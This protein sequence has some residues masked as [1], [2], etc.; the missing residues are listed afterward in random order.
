MEI[1][2]ATIGH[3][4]AVYRLMCELECRD[5][6]KYAFLRIYQ[7]NIADANVCYML[8]VDK[9]N[10]VGFASLHMQKLLHYCAKTGEIQEIIISEK[11][12][13]LGAE[14]ALFRQMVKTAAANGC[15]YLEVCARKVRDET[16]QF[17]ISQ[18][19][20][21]SHFKFMLDLAPAARG[22]KGLGL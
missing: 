10:I 6:D 4:D 9:N 7:E 8:A 14:A 18:G 11:Y 12:Q 17:Y 19:M 2:K 1:I 15:L 3:L 22:Q 5:L 16:H 21:Q 13:G 20:E